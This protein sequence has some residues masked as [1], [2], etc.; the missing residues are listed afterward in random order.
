MH[1]MK[2]DHFYHLEYSDYCLHLCC[3]INKISADASFGLLQE[4]TRNFEPNNLYNPIIL[5][6]LTMTGYKF[7]TT[8]KNP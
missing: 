8:E 7:E 5:I 2:L 1:E 4:S 6:L 3:Y